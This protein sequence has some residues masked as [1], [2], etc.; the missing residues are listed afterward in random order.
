MTEAGAAPVADRAT[1]ALARAAGFSVPL[2]PEAYQG[3]RGP[4]LDALTD[5]LTLLL[6]ELT[7]AGG[8]GTTA[9]QVAA[10]LGRCHA[11]RFI[12]DGTPADRERALPLLEQ[13]LGSPLL[14]EAD[15]EAAYRDL[16][17]LV[18]SRLMRL[19]RE[20]MAVTPGDWTV[21][22]LMSLAAE[23]TPLAQGGSGVV[24]DSALLVRLLLER[25][26][27]RMEPQL[28]ENLRTFGEMTDALLSGDTATLVR[29]GRRIADTMADQTPSASLSTILSLLLGQMERGPSGETGEAPADDSSGSSAE[30]RH[31][32]S[33]LLALAE[34]MSPGTM[35]PQHLS[36]LLAELSGDPAGTATEGGPAP[37]PS[38]MVAALVHVALA[39]RTGDMEGFRTALRL[40]HE[41]SVNGELDSRSHGEWLRTVVP[42]LLLGAALTG[43]S[44][45]DE[46]MARELLEAQR[47][48]DDPT[49][50]LAA[51]LRLCGEAVRLHG[52]VT[53]ALDRGDVG[54]VEDAIDELCEL[55]LDET[56]DGAEE[57][58][59]ALTGFVLGMAYLSRVVLVPSAEDRT[60]HLR[61]AVHHLQRAVETSVDM[62]VLRSLLDITWAPLIT[63]TAIAES[64]PSRIAEG[65]QRARAALDATGFTSDFRPRA[66]GG[67]ALALDTLHLLTGDTGALDEAID[68]LTQALTEFP[69]GGPG[70]AGLTW[71][72]AALHAKRAGLRA[73][74]DGPD[75][76][77]RAGVAGAGGGPGTRGDGADEAP[78][79]GV[80]GVD[81]GLSVGGSGVGGGSRAGGSGAVPAVPAGVSGVDGGLSVGGAGADG[82]LRAGGFGVDDDLRA[83]VGLA[84]RSLRLSADDVLLQQGV[85]RGLRIARAAAE[86]GRRAAFWALRAGLTEEAIACLEAGRSLVLGAAAVSAGVADR[87]AALGETELADRWREAAAEPSWERTDDGR[88]LLELSAE[89]G[90]GAGGAVRGRSPVETSAE[91]GE[92]VD[93]ESRGRDSGAASADGGPGAAGDVRGRSS[94]TVPADGGPVAGGDARGRS[95]LGMDADGGPGAPGEARGRSPLEVLAAVGSG[96]PG[97]PGDLRRRSLELLRGQGGAGMEPVVASVDDLRAGL[98]ATEADALLYLVPGLDDSDGAVLVVPADGPVTALP[99]PGLTPA[100]RGP[101]ARYLAAGA[102]R[103]RLEAADEDTANPRETERAER[104]WL[105]ALDDLCAW[106]GGVLGPALDHLA[107]WDRALAEAGLTAVAA[108]GAGSRT[109]DAPPDPSAPGTFDPTHPHPAPPPAVRL[110]IVPCGELGVVPWQAGVLE[111]PGVARGVRVCEVGVLTYAA[112]GREFLRAAARRRMA[113]GERPALVFHAADDLEWAEE[114]IETLA[115]V[116]YPGA[117]VHHPDDNPATPETVLALLGGRATAPASLVHLA[118]HG[119]AGPDPTRSAL[120]LAA[121]SEAGESSGGGALTLSTLLETPAEGDAFRAAGPL[122]VCGGCET[123]LTTRDHDE[124]LTVTSVLVHRLAADAIGSRWKVDD[125]RSELLMLVL[126][127]ALARGLAPPDA[128]RAAQRWMLTPPGER[129]PVPALHG[130]SAPWRLAEDFRD[131]PDTWA[132]FVHHGNPAPAAPA[133][134][135][136]G[137][138]V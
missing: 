131:R 89:V 79:A 138:R 65:V 10:R 14:G 37:L 59:G 9:A 83:A 74:A 15:R 63:L 55:E 84:R 119:L 105:R 95:S 52:R 104:R 108:D 77:L 12:L 73:D 72:L 94:L 36:G 48:D 120:H 103:Q 90:A 43:G 30:T 33:Q 23:G 3:I 85:G 126:H 38:R 19:S 137:E 8:D 116:H 40:M 99:L 46:D 76:A 54:E 92:E 82:G 28:R 18:A 32:L 112:S 42:G 50:D 62:P 129:P 100:G 69:D 16:V 125:M 133:R 45:Q 71:D 134:R 29:G 135:W 86:R 21:D 27:Q 35:A 78:P 102:D 31:L 51:S 41:A 93:D 117:L 114:E 20:A 87:L 39:T 49:S 56:Y 91:A 130:L 107:L 6:D 7:R 118:C 101:V 109:V 81:G 26:H 11:V 75:G 68:E 57:W 111:V 70:G 17:G 113:L 106:A 47:W 5:E 25:E 127:D 98:R 4:Q 132:A 88:S 136:E 22:R 97:L 64:D 80:S 122:V 24:E 53:S 96:V 124:A 121:S 60:A 110:V 34:V 128:L 61:A 66:R 1:A 115:G 44:L 58:T 123:D 2:E 13:A 67:I